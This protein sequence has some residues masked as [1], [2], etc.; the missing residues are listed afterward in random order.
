MQTITLSWPSI[1]VSLPTGSRTFLRVRITAASNGMGVNNA[2]RWFSNGEVE[3]YPVYVQVI[4]PITL[5]NFH[6]QAEDNAR[7]KLNWAT[8]KEISFKGFDVERSTDGFTWQKIDFVPANANG[9]LTNNYIL[10]DRYPETGTSYYRLKLL[11]DDGRYQ[12]SAVQFVNI[13][14][15]SI[16]IRITPNPVKTAAQLT[17]TCNRN[18]E[19]NIFVVDVNG[20]KLMQKTFMAS[21]G[22]NHVQLDNVGRLAPG[23]YMVQVITSGGAMQEKLVRQ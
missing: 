2:T 4:L 12:Y 6:A 23:M 13:K 9:A 8:G 14:Q 1:P 5:L 17:F 16:G 10:Y 3:D 7:V 15:L 22:L 18:E 20:R 11:S 19:V 21:P